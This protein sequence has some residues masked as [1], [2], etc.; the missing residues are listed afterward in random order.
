MLSSVLSEEFHLLF[1]SLDTL[2][3]IGIYLYRV[4]YFA[5]SLTDLNSL[6][7]GVLVKGI[8]PFTGVLL[9]IN[10]KFR[11]LTQEEKKNPM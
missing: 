2:I 8:C 3:L 10:E 5:F 9:I 6:S 7:F 4:A 1:S 11:K